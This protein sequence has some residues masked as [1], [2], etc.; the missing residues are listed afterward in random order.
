MK[1]NYTYFFV[2]SAKSTFLGVSHIF[3][4]IFYAFIC[5]E[6]GREDE[7]ETSAGWLSRAPNV[8]TGNQTGDL[9]VHRPVLNPP[10]HTSQ[11]ICYRFLVISLRVPRDE[12]G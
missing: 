10:S 1:Q 7:R 12:K 6:R 3:K 4:K 2:R 9:L 5:R 11:G 8:P